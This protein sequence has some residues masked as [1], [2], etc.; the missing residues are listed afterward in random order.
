MDNCG[1]NIYGVPIYQVALALQE[2]K[3]NPTAIFV[4][5]AIFQRH[6]DENRRRKYLV[7][8]KKFVGNSS[9]IPTSTDRQYSDGYSDTFFIGRISSVIGQN[10]FPTNRRQKNVRQNSDDDVTPIF[11]RQLNPSEFPRARIRRSQSEISDG[12]FRRKYPMDYFVG[13]NRRTISSEISDASCSSEYSEERWSSEFSDVTC[14]RKFPMEK[15]LSEYFFFIISNNLINF[16]YKSIKTEI[17]NNIIQ[18]RFT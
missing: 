18:K 3:R 10:I 6:S 15:V 13:N 8:K 14:R 5:M 2:N 7:G 1:N 11:R 17:K 12:Q 4:G 9:Q 16:F